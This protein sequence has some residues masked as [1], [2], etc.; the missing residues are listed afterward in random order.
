VLTRGL[1][2]DE[3]WI[4]LIL[5]GKKTW[6]MRSANTKIRGAIGLIRKR[7]GQV[8]GIAD[9]V[10]CRPPLNQR[11]Y[12]GQETFHRIPPDRQPRA[13]SGGWTRP[14]VL[15]NARRLR[16]PVPYRHPSGAVIW[17]TLDPEVITGI[18]ES[19]PTRNA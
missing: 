2:I 13:I 10:D 3:P 11:D 14:W 4:G 7:S 12:A 6:E 19:D 9:L 1:I 16:Q 5:S 18:I 15:A 17:V 8:V